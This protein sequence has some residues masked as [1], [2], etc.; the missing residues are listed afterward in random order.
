VTAGYPTLDAFLEVLAAVAGSADV[1]E[2]GV[3][4]TDPMADGLTIQHASHVALDNGVTL[5]WIFELL[6]DTDLGSPHLLMGYYNPFLAF[7][8]GRLGQAMEDSGTSG[9]IIPDLPFEE[10]GPIKEVLDPGGLALVQLVTPSTSE[11]RLGRVA[12]TGGGFVYAVTTAGVT[13]GEVDLP[14]EALEYLD[15]AKSASTLPVLAG[16]GVR[17]QS[18]VAALAPHVDGVVV[19][20]A[21]IEA[22]DKGED[23]GAFLDGLRLAGVSA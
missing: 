18:Q 7:G 4:F 16:F 15:R 2:I 20:S 22:I 19:G 17:T 11:E 12:T 3:P 5:E 6:G 14:A 21:L 1:V 10:S 8:L 13:G 9:L 23:P